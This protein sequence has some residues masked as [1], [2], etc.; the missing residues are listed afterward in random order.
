MTYKEMHAGIMVLSAVLVAGWVAYDFVGG[1][2]A[3]VTEAAANM[4][5]AIGYVIAFNIVGAIVAVIIFSIV[6]REPLT[7][8]A[9]D[10]RDQL[11]VSKA[12][13]NGYF[14]LSVGVLVVLVAQALGLDPA[15][16]P[17]GLFAIS[18]L[19]GG[20]FAASQLV[21]YRIG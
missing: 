21:Y 14:V 8:E 10:E 13:R 11:V 17:Y 1:A 9:A 19:A 2:A 16:G 4:L 5:W 18:I 20:I 3:T 7:D 6:R 15:L 12:M